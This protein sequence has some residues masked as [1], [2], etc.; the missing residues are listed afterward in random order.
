MINLMHR[1]DKLLSPI[2]ARQDRNAAD[3]T[4]VS[5]R[6]C[7]QSFTLM[8]ELT[9]LLVGGWTA[10]IVWIALTDGHSTH[11]K[12]LLKIMLSALSLDL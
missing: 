6:T 8:C 3:C 10:R 4:G 1:I 12:V 7:G 9:L 5:G 11:L 2:A